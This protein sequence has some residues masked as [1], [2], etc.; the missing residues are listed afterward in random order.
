MAHLLLLWRPEAT[1]R[2]DRFHFGFIPGFISGFIP[3]FIPLVPTPW[4]PPPVL[5][6]FHS[7]CMP[8]PHPGIIPSV[9]YRSHTTVSYHGFIP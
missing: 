9:S 5:Y 1:N 6:R 3:G 7:G 2:Q 8:V 4:Y